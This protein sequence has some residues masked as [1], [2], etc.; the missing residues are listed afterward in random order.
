VPVPRAAVFAGF[1]RKKGVAM[2]HVGCP[3]CRVRFTQAAAAY[4]SDCPECGRPLQSV[5]NAEGVL[6]FRIYI[7]EDVPQ[8]MP[9]AVAIS[10]PIVD[11]ARPTSG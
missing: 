7:P 8:Q 1:D 11:P 3:T 5:A 9:E 10:I 2:T 6:G 4:L